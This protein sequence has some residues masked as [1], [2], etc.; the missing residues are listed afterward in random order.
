MGKD[1]RM[2]KWEYTRTKGKRR[3]I[4]SNGVLGWGL[5]T[6]LLF[7]GITNMVEH[8][9]S[10]Q[11]YITGEGIMEMLISLIIF[12]LGGVIFGYMVWGLNESMYADDQSN[13]EGSS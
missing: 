4:I 6:A 1:K 10:L 13:H 5:P 11:S 2:E 9:M 12:P 7:F 3:F 8:G